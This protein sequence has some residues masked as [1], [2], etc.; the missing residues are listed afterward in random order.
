MRYGFMKKL[1]LIF[2][3]LVC[4]FAFVG[5]TQTGGNGG[6]DTPGGN[7][8]GKKT[9]YDVL[10]ELTKVNYATIKLEATTTVD[11]ESLKGEYVATAIDGGYRVDY[12]YEKINTFTESDGEIVIPDEYKSEFSGSAT[13]KNGTVTEQ[14]GA[15]CDFPIGGLTPNFKFNE[16]YFS[17][18]TEKA[19]EFSAK[20]KNVEAFLGKAVSCT[21]MTVTVKYSDAGLNSLTLR[22]RTSAGEAVTVYTFQE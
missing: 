21:D 20:V 12:K 3:L 2:A 4:A 5:C 14:S 7:E 9:A 19:G 22:Y 10:N 18:V 15:E 1:G 11:G 16:K 6:N 8:G 13:V 17:D